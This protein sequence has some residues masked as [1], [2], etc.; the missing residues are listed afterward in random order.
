MTLGQHWL[1][2]HQPSC[3]SS[4]LHA[5]QVMVLCELQ[6][7]PEALKEWHQGY[8]CLHAL[9]NITGKKRDCTT[10]CYNVKG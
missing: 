3:Y 1:R 2:P 4:I 5:S 9:S 8:I 7:Q 6:A 10:V